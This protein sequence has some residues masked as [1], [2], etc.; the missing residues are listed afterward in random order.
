MLV[1][2]VSEDSSGLV[3]HHLTAINFLQASDEDF[4]TELTFS[5]AEKENGEV[6]LGCMCN[7]GRETLPILVVRFSLSLSLS[8]QNAG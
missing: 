5:L 4:F 6:V 7:L 2:P 1:C 3:D 8:I